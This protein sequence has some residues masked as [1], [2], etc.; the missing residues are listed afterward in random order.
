MPHCDIVSPTKLFP[1][2]HYYS[3]G[4]HL[5]H[6]RWL[7]SDVGLRAYAYYSYMGIRHHCRPPLR[8]TSI[9]RSASYHIWLVDHDVGL[10]L[11]GE[12]RIQNPPTAV[13][14][15]TGS[16]CGKSLAENSTPSLAA[17]VLYRCV[18]QLLVSLKY[19]EIVSTLYVQLMSLS[20]V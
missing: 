16:A 2:K 18:E 5:I 6:A 17:V 7:R 8:F 14:R 13:I 4:L 11:A 20:I 9:R 3:P 10:A 19:V 15:Y 1:Q 12:R